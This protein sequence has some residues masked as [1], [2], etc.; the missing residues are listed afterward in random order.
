MFGWVCRYYVL[1]VSGIYSGYYIIYFQ[2]YY[3]YSWKCSN[4]GTVFWA[5][6]G[7]TL[8][9]TCGIFFFLI[10]R[11]IPDP[12]NYRLPSISRHH[13]MYVTVSRKFLFHQKCLLA[14]LIAARTH[15]PLNHSVSFSEHCYYLPYYFHHNIF[16]FY[17]NIKD[18]IYLCFFL[19][20]VFCATVKNWS[21]QESDAELGR[22]WCFQGGCEHS[23]IP[24]VWKD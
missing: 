21:T 10:H 13:Q 2:W 8:Q 24:A 5:T 7:L 6:V 15:P 11:N 12:L 19:F 9:T 1:V 23:V 3:A 18:L 17:L 16:V 22:S 14:C 4:I 20:E